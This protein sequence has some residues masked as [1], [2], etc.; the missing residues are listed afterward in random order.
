MARAAIARGSTWLTARLGD[1]F[2]SS[3]RSSR[4]QLNA[5]RSIAL[6]KHGAQVKVLYDTQSTRLHAKA[7]LFR[8]ATGFSTAY[9]GSSNLSKSAL[10]DGVEWNVRLSQVGTPDILEKFDATFETYW[11][12]PEYES[13]DR[14]ATA[15][16]STARLLRTPAK[17]STRHRLFLDAEPWPHQRE[18]LEKLAVER[19]RITASRIS[20]WPR[21]EPARP[22]LQH[23]TTRGCESSTA[24]CDCCLSPTDKKY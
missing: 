18:M 8:R 12:S 15:L 6:V 11:A 9:I 19:N 7:W 3:R 17:H 22:L 23:W 24:I 20:L 16:D 1:R 13:Y 5:K 10:V 2:E 21:L 14:H 4:V